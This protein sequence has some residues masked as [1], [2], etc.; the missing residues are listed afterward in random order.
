LQTRICATCDCFTIDLVA[1]I[2]PNGEGFH[3]PGGKLW[4]TTVHPIDITKASIAQ[5]SDFHPL[6]SNN[7]FLPSS[8]RRPGYRLAESGAILLYLPAEKPVS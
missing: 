1:W 3:R 7:A 6:Q 4:A 5:A 8:I 2:T